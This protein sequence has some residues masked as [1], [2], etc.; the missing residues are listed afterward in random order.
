MSNW[1]IV[2]CFV[3]ALVCGRA[4][5]AAEE[6]LIGHYA[7]LTGSEATFG[8]STDNGVRLAVEEVNAK[9][10]INGKKIRLIT[11]DDEGKTDKAGDAVKRMI[12]SDHVVAI[13]GEVSSGLSLAGGAVC[14]EH[15]IPM[16]SPS[17]TNPKVTRI[18]NMIFR[19]CFTDPFQAYV[20]AKFARENK[21]VQATRVATLYDKQSPYSTGLKQEFAKSFKSLG[22][23]ITAEESYTQGDSDFSAQL[24][25]I[26][27]TNPQVVFIPGYY[28]DVASIAVQAR[29]L[30]LN[31]PLL[32]GDGWDSAKLAE[33][34][35]ASIEG[36]YYSNHCT[37]ED[38]NPQVQE[39]LKKYQAKHQQV[40]DA[41]A[42][43]G[44]DS[45]GILFDALRRSK[46]VT[47]ADLAAAIAATK[48]FEGITGRITI[49]EA[50]NASKP[51]VILKM[52]K[53]KPLLV[54]TIAPK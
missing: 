22:G 44:Y 16:I 3:V 42:E 6:I 48:N 23:T 52:T 36:C 38:P 12:T 26:R 50:R 46:S 11:R 45:A 51:A 28:T 15:S 39:F 8:Q 4:S 30:E 13:I 20:C 54:E 18:G 10:G 32:G 37:V 17:S 47:G 1:R 29:K 31:V 21:A 14:Q 35:G 40:P 25:T 27:G 7:S 43:L 33:I 41:L 5:S 2:L 49:D 9:G 53:G 34:A 24:T 19:V